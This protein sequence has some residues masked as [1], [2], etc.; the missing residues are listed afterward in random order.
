MSR[1]GKKPVQ[2]PQGVEVNLSGQ[3]VAAKGPKGEL[4]VT[5]SDYVT[6]AQGDEGVTVT[7]LRLLSHWRC[8]SSS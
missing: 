6:V 3:N 8:I 1:I 5:L 2:V 7:C 4:A